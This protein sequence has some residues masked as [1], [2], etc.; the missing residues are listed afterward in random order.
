MKIRTMYKNNLI[1]HLLMA[2]WR[3]LPL[4]EVVQS[5]NCI[6]LIFHFHGLATQREDFHNRL[7]WTKLGSHTAAK[8]QE[9]TPTEQRFPPPPMGYA[10]KH[11]TDLY[12]ININNY[13]E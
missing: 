6:H 10:S 13:Y 4:V 1:G 12:P 3:N 11:M 2:C 5:N 8:R 7:M 9:A